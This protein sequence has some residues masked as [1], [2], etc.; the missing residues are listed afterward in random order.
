MDLRDTLHFQHVHKAFDG[1]PVLRGLTARLP[2]GRITYVVGRSGQGKS[3]LC[4]LAVGLEQPDAG[5]ILL[6]GQ[7]VDTLSRTGRLALRRQ[8]PYLVQ[9]PALLDWLTLRENVALAAQQGPGVDVDGA[10]ARVGVEGWADARP[11]DVS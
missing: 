8:F 1:T 2:L 10:L 6:A 5:E 9:S 3:V 11:P 7:R 4:R